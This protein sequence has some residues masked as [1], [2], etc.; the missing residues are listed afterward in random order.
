MSKLNYVHEKTRVG[1][2]RLLGGARLLF[3][4]AILSQAV[5]VAGRIGQNFVLK[6]YIDDAMMADNWT[7]HLMNFAL[8]FILL[9]AV[10]GGFSFLAARGIA[11]TAEGIG[12]RLRNDLYDHIQRL[13]F[14]YHGKTKTGELIQRVTSDVETIA[15]FFGQQTAELSRIFF[16][17]CINFGAI[18]FMHWKLAVLSVVAIPFILLMSYL[19]FKR[20]H[21]AYEKYQELDA[22]VQ[23]VLQ[24]NLS[25]VRIVRAFARQEFEQQ[26]FEEENSEKF[27][28]GKKFTMA[29]A[30]YW[31]ISHLIC[32]FQMIAGIAFGGLLAYRG[33]ISMGTYIAYTGMVIGLIWPMQHLGR[34]IAQ[35]STSFVSYERITGVLREEQVDLTTGVDTELRGSVEFRDLHFE[36]EPGIPVLNG[37]TAECRPGET[38]ALLG[39]TGSGKTSLVNLIPR[40]Y[41]VTSGKLLV[42]GRPVNEY[43]R[44][45]LRRN[46][47]IVEQ[48][49]FLFS[50]TIRENI[51][52]GA[53]R[54]VDQ[55][56]VEAAARAAAIHDSIVSFPKGYDTI[57]GERG[58][59]L[60][61]GQK[62]RVTLA[63]TI[64]KDPKILILD[65]ATASVDAET[66]EEIRAALNRLMENRTT[67][68]IAHKVQSVMKAD[69][70]LV[71]HKGEIIQ[72]GTHATLVRQEGFYRDV[73]LMQ[74]RTDEVEDKEVVY[75]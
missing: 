59:T 22:R 61:G 16:M 60:S 56:E 55:A 40:F 52:Y 7:G 38:V 34:T 15:V 28:M 32:S 14:K 43:A 62:Q 72:R 54:E 66:E 75:V 19:F 70:I 63:R 17:F 35:L 18:L 4:A 12:R 21:K 25:G 36:Y 42:D 49:P 46:I 24:E 41:E 3:F 57:V 11:F 44:H 20:I 48:E 71:F 29:H 74:T 1:L 68:V 23:S 37:V 13:S 45:C 69:Q 73:Y 51:I 10:G 27:R 30:L 47:G 8:A 65:D 31:P 26:K 9:A 39:T 64:L 2:W 67:F 33:E 5:A 58:V 50:T 53:G 6:Y